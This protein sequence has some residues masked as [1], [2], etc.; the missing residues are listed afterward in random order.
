MC[1]ESWSTRNWKRAS[2]IWFNKENKDFFFL[3]VCVYMHEYAYKCRYCGGQKRILDSPGAVV[4]GYYELSDMSSG[5]WT[6]VLCKSTKHSHHRA[7]SPAIHKLS[8]EA[9]LW[10]LTLKGAAQLSLG[11]TFSVLVIPTSWHPLWAW[12]SLDSGRLTTD[13]PG[14]R[15]GDEY[16]T[17]RALVFRCPDN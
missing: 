11:R 2:V 1:F 5:N 3:V 6:R 12:P 17:H 8:F 15:D 9:H 4:P 7:L 13:T 14:R 16:S 10:F